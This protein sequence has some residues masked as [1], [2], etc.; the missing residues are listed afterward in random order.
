MRP[1]IDKELYKK[2]NYDVQK[3][4]AAKSQAFFDEKLSES[5]GLP[6]QL[7]N[8][9]KSLGMPKTTVVSNFKA[10]DDNKSLTC[11]IKECQNFS[12]ISSQI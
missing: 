2:A 5:V 4:I 7:W 10:I 9:L 12:K 8:S 3:L 11:D 6:K 1:H